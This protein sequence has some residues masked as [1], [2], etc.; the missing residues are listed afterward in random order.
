MLGGKW[1]VPR[2]QWVVSAD[3]SPNTFHLLKRSG[4]REQKQVQVSASFS[5]SSLALTLLFSLWP[6]RPWYLGQDKSHQDG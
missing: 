4:Q 1:V 3:K 5:Q 6:S 2:G